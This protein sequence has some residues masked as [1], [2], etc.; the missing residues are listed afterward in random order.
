MTR[1]TIMGM[2]IYSVQNGDIFSAIHF[3][4]YSFTE[5]KQSKSNISWLNK[6]IQH[7]DGESPYPKQ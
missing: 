6:K 3:F 1:Q 4:C 2:F 7:Q 5:F